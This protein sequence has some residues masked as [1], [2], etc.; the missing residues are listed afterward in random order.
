MEFLVAG[1]GHLVVVERS[2]LLFS[3]LR[4]CHRIADRFFAG[5]RLK[6]HFLFLHLAVLI[7]TL[8]LFQA[9]LPPTSGLRHT[10]PSYITTV[11]TLGNFVFL[12]LA[13]RGVGKVG[14]YI[15]AA[16]HRTD[17]TLYA[18]G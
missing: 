8:P 5:N 11:Y 12:G 18:S 16:L 4:P 10:L 14:P 6:L 2:V 15:Q 13:Q 3:E 7:C 17:I 9:L 1:C